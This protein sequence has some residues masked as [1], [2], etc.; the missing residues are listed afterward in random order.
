MGMADPRSSALLSESQFHR[1][2]ERCRAEIAS[3]EQQL[4]A[5]HLDVEGS[6]LSIYDWTEELRILQNEH[7]RLL[8]GGGC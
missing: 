3:A 1:E 2:M 4:R 5:G 7:R 6:C 8:G